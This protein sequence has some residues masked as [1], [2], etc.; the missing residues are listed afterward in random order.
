MTDNNDELKAYRELKQVVDESLGMLWECDDA[1]VWLDHDGGGQSAWHD[2]T[3]Q[4]KLKPPSKGKR[5]WL[6]YEYQPLNYPPM[7][8]LLK[9]LSLEELVFRIR[10]TLF[11]WQVVKSKVDGLSASENIPFPRL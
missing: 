9:W 4:L 8:S 7:C 6:V 3:D 2:V 10:D 1:E 5:L 11:G